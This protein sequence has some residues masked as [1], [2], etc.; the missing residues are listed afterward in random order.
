MSRKLYPNQTATR[1]G[2]RRRALIPL[3]ALALV[4][5]MAAAGA[6]AASSGYDTFEGSCEIPATVVFDPPLT[7]STQQ[8]HAEADGRGP[9]T[10]TWTTAAGRTYTL[11]GATV[12]YHAEA[13][14]QQSCAGS[15]GTTGPGFFRYRDRKIKFTFF[16][17]RV[18]A[19]TPIRLEG[20]RGGVFEGR[21]DPSEDTDPVEVLQKC[22]STGLDEA[23]V[24]I[25][26][27]TSPSISG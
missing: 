10:G 26:G 19:L 9:C 15:E 13:D 17:S 16:E 2:G 18:G 4:L 14:G 12:M 7:G 6:A 21:A 24:V 1:E 25:R 3:I 5:G 11:D 22:A 20:R 27:S 8:V 23:S